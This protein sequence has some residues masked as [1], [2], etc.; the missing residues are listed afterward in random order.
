ML[1][2][3]KPSI[4]LLLIAAAGCA[5]YRVGAD[6]LYAPDIR[7]VQ[8]PMIAS[9][10]LRRDLGERLTEAVV[11]EIN[12]KTPFRVVN[13][14]TADSLLVVRLLDD[15]RRVLV[16]DPYDSPRLFENQIS[17]EVTWINRRRDPMLA[18]PTLATR[19]M[20][21]PPGLAGSAQNANWFPAAGQ[22]V[23]SSQQQTIERLAQQIVGSMEE[24]W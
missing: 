17:V 3:V 10:S 19:T 4:A 20:A 24:P 5:N 7:T 6:A 18:D 11:R 22:S 9:D 15:T 21:L 2:V 1:S 16:E 12:T 14:P 8:V 23:A 13:D